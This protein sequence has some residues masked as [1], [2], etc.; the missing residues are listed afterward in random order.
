MPV[1][2]GDYEIHRSFNEIVT[3]SYGVIIKFD[4]GMNRLYGGF[5][6]CVSLRVKVFFCVNDRLSR[7]SET[8]GLN[9]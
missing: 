5:V 1:R 7:F 3:P 9:E 2:G 8:G 4:E 6:S